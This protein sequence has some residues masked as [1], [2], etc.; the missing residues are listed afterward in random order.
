MRAHALATSTREK[1]IA[2]E[3]E[4]ERMKMDRDGAVERVEKEKKQAE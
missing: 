1:N 2:R 4:K 3:R